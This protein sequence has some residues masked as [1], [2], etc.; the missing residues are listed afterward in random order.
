MDLLKNYS[1]PGN[2]RELENSLERIVLISD[3]ATMDYEDVKT[4]INQE[5]L[6]SKPKVINQKVNSVEQNNIGKQYKCN[7]QCH[8]IHNIL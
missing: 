7:T 1:W 6:I 8:N 3:K 4:I 5:S 2:I